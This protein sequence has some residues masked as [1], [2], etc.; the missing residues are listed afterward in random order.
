MTPPALKAKEFEELIL[1]GAARCPLMTLSRYGVQ[2]MVGTDGKLLAVPSL[3][4]FEGA[5]APDGRQFIIEAKV[6][7]QS[8]FP[9]TPDKIKP[10]QVRHMLERSRF[11]VACFVAIHFAE[12]IG[13]T[14]HEPGETLALPVSDRLGFWQEFLDAAAE[15]KRTKAPFKSPG[16]LSRDYAARIGR[17]VEWT[18]PKGSRKHLPDLAALLGIEAGQPS[19]F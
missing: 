19:L 9:L 7:A 1:A 14:F 12:R 10:R 4:D 6:C 13:K 8:A 5:V 2:T 11:G 3:P 15:A 17:R 16:S 18:C